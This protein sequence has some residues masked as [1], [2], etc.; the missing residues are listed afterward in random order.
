ML[1]KIAKLPGFSRIFWTDSLQG[2]SISETVRLQCR[3][4]DTLAV[5]FCKKCIVLIQLRSWLRLWVCQKLV[6]FY[7]SV[8]DRET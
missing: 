7:V 5:S 4:N 1:E 2:Q 3:Q 8:Q 6:G